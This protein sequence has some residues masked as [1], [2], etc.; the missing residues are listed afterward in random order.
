MRSSRA[1]AKAGSSGMTERGSVMV[2]RS[3]GAPMPGA[4]TKP[5]GPARGRWAAGHCR[6]A[7]SPSASG[8]T[9][10]PCG[11]AIQRPGRKAPSSEGQSVSGLTSCTRASRPQVGGSPRSA[12]GSG[13][14]AWR[15]SP[16]APGSTSRRGRESSRRPGGGSPDPRRGRRVP[17]PSP[18]S[19]RSAPP[20]R[21]GSRRPACR[22]TISGSVVRP[23]SPSACL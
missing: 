7:K 18:R 22:R 16:G 5:S 14:G 10:R 23:L 17:C 11:A 20:G 15:G 19:R 21:R 4:Y 9:L 3:E 2:T 8:G 1:L 13:R 12:S 6:A